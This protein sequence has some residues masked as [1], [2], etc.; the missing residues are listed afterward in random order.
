M[1]NTIVAIVS[2]CNVLF[3]TFEIGRVSAGAQLSLLATVIIMIV[4]I[5]TMIEAFRKPSK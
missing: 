1:Y 2:I 4:S 3:C 5:F